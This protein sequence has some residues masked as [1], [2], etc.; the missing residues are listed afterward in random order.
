MTLLQIA[1][2][3]GEQISENHLAFGEVTGKHVVAPF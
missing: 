2:A 1:E 3:C